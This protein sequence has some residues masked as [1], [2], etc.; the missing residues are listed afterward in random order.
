M[1]AELGLSTSVASAPVVPARM[2][3]RAQGSARPTCLAS[4]PS[5]APL[6]CFSI[7]GACWV[8]L[9][10]GK[11]RWEPHHPCVPP[12]LAPSPWWGPYGPPTLADAVSCCAA[13]LEASLAAALPGPLHLCAAGGT[14]EGEVASHTLGG[15]CRDKTP[16]GHPSPHLASWTTGGGRESSPQSFLCR[17]GGREVT[18]QSP[19]EGQGDRCTEH[20]AAGT[21]RPWALP[22]LTAITEAP[23]TGFGDSFLCI[24]LFL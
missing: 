14:A 16:Q 17:Q 4:L 15:S 11:Q 13:Q 7:R 12:I 8:R 18:D 24:H 23:N 2:E 20:S 22:M 5:P 19:G 6:R 3:R 10:V 1:P 21:P 9:Q